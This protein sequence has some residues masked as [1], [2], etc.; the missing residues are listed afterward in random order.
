[1]TDHDAFRSA[2]ESHDRLRDR[3]AMVRPRPAMAAP[4]GEVPPRSMAA[5]Q[6]DAG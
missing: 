4:L 3:T 5:P 1:M 6:A 2:V